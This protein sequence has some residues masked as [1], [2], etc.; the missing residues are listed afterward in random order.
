MTGSFGKP[1]FDI[2][3]ASAMSHR[4]LGVV[5]FFSA[6]LREIN[7]RPRKLT[8]RRRGA[9]KKEREAST[10]RRILGVGQSTA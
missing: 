10:P 8:Q 7:D 6:P 5:L 9:E 3:Q 4:D 1:I 2:A